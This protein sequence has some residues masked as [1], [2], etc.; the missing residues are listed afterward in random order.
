M[1]LLQEIFPTQ[2]S[3]PGRPHCRQILYHLSHQSSPR[4]LEW[5][6]YP[7][8]RGSSQ[9]RNQIR[10]SCLAGGF[11]TSWATREAPQKI[12]P[13]CYFLD[14]LP[15]LWYV[16]QQDRC[17]PDQPTPWPLFPLTQLHI[18]F[19]CEAISWVKPK[20][21]R[22]PKLPGSLGTGVLSLPVFAVGVGTLLEEAEISLERLYPPSSPWHANFSFLPSKPVET[23]MLIC[24]SVLW[25]CLL[26]GR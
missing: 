20:E 6:G 21:F 16:D 23:R 11:F 1:P 25:L 8:S 13:C 18:H 4:I 24:W 12:L 3:N 10:A 14:K 15:G 22:D 19:S 5:I 2:G 9:L 7:F 17:H 26:S